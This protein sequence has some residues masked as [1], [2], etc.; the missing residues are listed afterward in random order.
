MLVESVARLA[1]RNATL[2][3][4]T[5]AASDAL[6]AL[7]VPLVALPLAAADALVRLVVLVVLVVWL[8]VVRSFGRWLVVCQR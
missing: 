3:A 2:A 4:T 1:G 8:F 5:A 6:V 7:G